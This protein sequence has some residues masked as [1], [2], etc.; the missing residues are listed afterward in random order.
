M[1]ENNHTPQRE[2]HRLKE[3]RSKK[4][5]K[6]PKRNLTPAFTT[7]VSEEVSPETKK[8]VTDLSP[9]SE[10][11]AL[12]STPLKF[13]NVSLV[14]ET[15]DSCLL[16]STPSQFGDFSPVTLTP[17]EFSNFSPFSEA[18]DCSSVLR[19]T[20]PVSISSGNQLNVSI[21]RCVFHKLDG[22]V[23]VDIVS[24]F[25]KQARKQVLS[26]TDVDVKYKKIL[27][28]VLKIVLEECSD[29]PEERDFC[30]ELVSARAHTMDHCLPEKLQRKE[31]LD[32]RLSYAGKNLNYGADVE[33]GTG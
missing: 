24:D 31:M 22:S 10:S 29:L 30:A 12:K 23:E 19:Y 25:L 15:P 27:D 20:A 1:V 2:D 11:S 9:V 17:S 6:L 26:S 18:T 3:S 13:S 8:E 16:T 7:A 4:I 33:C 5:P 21:D 32:K 28:A 14:S